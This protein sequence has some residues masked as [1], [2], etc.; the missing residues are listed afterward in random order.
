MIDE[1]RL[2]SSTSSK[3]ADEAGYGSL[4]MVVNKARGGKLASQRPV[5]VEAMS[6]HLELFEQ[7]MRSPANEASMG[8]C[9]PSGRLSELP[10][11]QILRLLNLRAGAPVACPSEQMPV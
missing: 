8:P 1:L 3:P 5:N 11:S 9:S 7:E 10:W 2:S 4:F 6:A